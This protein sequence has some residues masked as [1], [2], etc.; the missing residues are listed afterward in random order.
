MFV[1]CEQSALSLKF[2]TSIFIYLKKG[3]LL[4]LCSD[5][6]VCDLCE[7]SLINI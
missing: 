4:L 5:I 2:L 6:E 3:V 1:N 7:Q